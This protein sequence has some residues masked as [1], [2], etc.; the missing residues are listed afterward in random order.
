MTPQE[1]S[2]GD[3]CTIVSVSTAFHPGAHDVHADTIFASSD[4][5]LFYVSSEVLKGASHNAFSRIFEGARTERNTSESNLAQGIMIPVPETSAVLNVILHMMYGSSAAQHSPAFETLTTVVERM[6]CYDLHPKNFIFPRAPL[7]EL[8]LAYAPLFPLPLYTL[9]GHHDL[10]DLAVATSSHLLSYPLSN[11]TDEVVEQMGAL[12]L[13]KLMCLHL[14][15][16]NALKQILL[17]PP[18]PHPASKEC[19]FMDQRRLTRAWALVAAYL[20]W[21]ARPGT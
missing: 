19:S 11:L 15:R 14:E 1:P 4:S 17:Q 18:H 8:L 7:Y 12:Y 21:D 10:Y 5:V 3:D 13:K 2:T 6:S 20:A 16:F 9:A